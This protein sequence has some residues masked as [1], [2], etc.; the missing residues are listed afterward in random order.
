MFPDRRPKASAVFSPVP[1][2]TAC[3]RQIIV[4]F[5]GR[6]FRRPLQTKEADPYVSLYTLARKQGILSRKGSQ[7][8]SRA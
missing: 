4:T 1:K 7:P 2:K 5:A 8:R 6:A 3:A